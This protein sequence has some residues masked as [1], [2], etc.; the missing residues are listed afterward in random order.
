MKQSHQASSGSRTGQIQTLLAN[1]EIAGPGRLSRDA[2]TSGRH[3]VEVQLIVIFDSR[4]RYRLLVRHQ[5]FPHDPPLYF[6]RKLKLFV[7]L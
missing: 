5:P 6:Q 1:A 7:H 3:E 4:A 2:D